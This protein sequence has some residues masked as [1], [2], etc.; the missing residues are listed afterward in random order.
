MSK[1][2]ISGPPIDCTGQLGKGKESGP[3]PLLPEGPAADSDIGSDVDDGDC[4]MRSR[5]ESPSVLSDLMSLDSHR[6]SRASSPNDISMEGT[7]QQLAAAPLQED[8]SQAT[9]NDDWVMPDAPPIT[10]P[11]M[12]QQQ[13]ETT[14]PTGHL[15]DPDL[16]RLNGQDVDMDW[17]EEP[18]TTLNKDDP[19]APSQASSDHVPLIPAFT[20]DADNDAVTSGPISS[21]AVPLRW[22]HYG[23]RRPTG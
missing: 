14:C 20:V 7:V 12:N 11:R 3:G 1:W 23:S 4:S 17:D 22:N 5:S 6:S 19:A 18:V 16:E 8:G 21:A 15:P 10:T 2:K 13:V 9:T